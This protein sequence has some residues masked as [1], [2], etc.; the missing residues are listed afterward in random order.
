MIDKLVLAPYYWTL[1][2]RHKLYDKGIRKVKQASVPTICIGNITVGGTGKTPHT[3]M[4]LDMLLKDT[5]LRGDGIAMLSRGYKRASRG[6]QQVPIDGTAVEYG[7]E[8]VQIKKKFPA[9]TVAVCKDR[10]LGCRFLT[11][12]ERLQGE[13]KGRHCRFKDFS[14][15]S[16]IVLDDAFQYRA[17]SHKASIVLVDYHRPIFKDHLMPMGQ[18][19]DI[20]ERIKAADIVIVSKCPHYMDP[21]ER[22]MWAG[23]LGIREGQRLFFTTIDYCPMEPVFVDGES[24]YL[25]SKRAILFTGIANDTPLLQYLSD[26]FKVVRHFNFPDHHAF[27]SKDIAQIRS[28]AKSYPTA[29]IATTDKDSYRLRDCTKVPETLRQKM[30]RVPIKVSFLS[31]GEREDFRQTLISLLKS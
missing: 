2:L 19:R 17:L 20:P 25:Y 18:L 31:E 6:F 26:S 13:R 16:L 27:T 30:F 24:R 7:D 21:E 23:K 15:A 14:P 11:E 5:E 29:V 3:E 12:P 4:I 1:R 22:E 10:V 28:A 8:P 9:V